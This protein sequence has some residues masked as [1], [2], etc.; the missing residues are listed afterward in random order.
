VN[1]DD[2]EAATPQASGEVDDSR[3]PWVIPA[4]KGAVIQLRDRD[5]YRVFDGSVWAGPFASV[6]EAVSFSRSLTL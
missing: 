1:K 4:M 3:G 2:D 6:D 5:E